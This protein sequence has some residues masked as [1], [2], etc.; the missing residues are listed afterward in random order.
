VERNPFSG[1]NHTLLASLHGTIHCGL[2]VP[3]GRLWLLFSA[4]RLRV[5]LSQV[6]LK[7]QKATKKVIKG[8]G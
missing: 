6:W 3:F 2:I 4:S 5:W 1:K 7:K 8:V